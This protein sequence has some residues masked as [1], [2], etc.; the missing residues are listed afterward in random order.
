MV[1]DLKQ[2]LDNLG[3]NWGVIGMKQSFE[4]E[5]VLLN[6][7]VAFKRVTEICG[8]QSF[9]KIGGCEA[10][11]DLYN[12]IRMGI[13]GVI[14]PMVETPFALDKFITMMKDYP[15]RADSYVVIESKTAYENIDNILENG[16]SHLKGIIVG[17]S[18]FSKSYNLNKSEVDSIFIYD[19]VE[20]ILTKAKKYG[21]ITT[22]GGNVSTRSTKFVKDAFAKGL[23]DR[24]ET[25]NVV[26]GLNKTNIVNIDNNIQKALDFEIEWLQYKLSISSKLSADYSE[27]IG[28]LKN[29]K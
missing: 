22:M 8:L 7:V 17:R 29:R 26:I 28:L 19:K 27:R 25:R 14:A 3:K 5:G 16:H 23:L 15:N 18:D 2:S 10:K 9:V 6:D 21:Y 4:D 13:N 11:S 1:I 24:I 12:C 20:D